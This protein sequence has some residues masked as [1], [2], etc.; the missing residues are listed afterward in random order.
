MESLNLME[1][2]VVCNNY[3]KKIIAYRNVYDSEL[4]EHKRVHELIRQTTEQNAE[5]ANQFENE[6]MSN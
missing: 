2:A 1:R 3:E 5:D 4:L 6:G